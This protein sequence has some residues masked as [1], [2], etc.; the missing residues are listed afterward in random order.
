MAVVE[1]N[2]LL[3]SP[4]GSASLTMPARF[5]MDQHDGVGRCHDA[6]LY[7]IADGVECSMLISFGK[8]RWKSM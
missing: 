8:V 2:G 5:N 1:V 7:P 4:H 3:H 6:L